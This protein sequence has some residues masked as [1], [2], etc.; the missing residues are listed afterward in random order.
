MNL[1][2]K[3]RKTLMDFFKKTLGYGYYCRN[4]KRNARIIE[5][6][7]DEHCFDYVNFRCSGCKKTW[8]IEFKNKEIKNLI[9]AKD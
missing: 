2:P 9:I 6:Y 3:Y 8:G 5:A 1:V 7:A 4:C